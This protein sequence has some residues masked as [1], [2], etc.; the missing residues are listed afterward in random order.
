MFLFDSTN[1]LKL[2]KFRVFFILKKRRISSMNCIR[3]KQNTCFFN[4]FF[5]GKAIITLILYRVIYI[6]PDSLVSFPE[7]SVWY[8]FNYRQEV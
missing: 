5:P 6:E 7:K 4:I 3:R 8:C 1:K 2:S